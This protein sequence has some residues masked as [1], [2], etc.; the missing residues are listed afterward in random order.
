MV[1]LV[2]LVITVAIVM[3]LYVLLDTILNRGSK[4]NKPAKWV[5]KSHLIDIKRPDGTVVNL[6]DLLKAMMDK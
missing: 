2:Q 5:F 4:D 6:E 3:F 1:I